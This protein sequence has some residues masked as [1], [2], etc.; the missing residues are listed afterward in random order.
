MKERFNNEKNQ[1]FLFLSQLTPKNII[2]TNNDDIVK[3]VDV[4][5]KYYTFEDMDFIDLEAMNLKTEIN[6]WKSKW[7][8]IKDEGVDV[9]TSAETCNEILYPTVKKLLFILSCLPVSVASAERS[10]STLRRLKTWLRSTMGQNRLSGLAL[11]HVHRSIS[12]NIDK[13]IDTFS[14]MKKRN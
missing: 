11:L 13:I 4:I 2:K 1:A 12:I 7:I 8:R 6:L 5:K 14:Q 10:F 3:V 9:I